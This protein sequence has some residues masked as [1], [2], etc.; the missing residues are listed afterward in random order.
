[1]MYNLSLNSAITNKCNC[2]GITV[3]VLLFLCSM[4][5]HHKKIFS[6][7]KTPSDFKNWTQ[8]VLK[9]NFLSAMFVCIRPVSAGWYLF[10]FVTTC[11]DQSGAKCWQNEKL[12]LSVFFSATSVITIRALLAFIFFNPNLKHFVKT[13]SSCHHCCVTE[14]NRVLALVLTQL[15]AKICIKFFHVESCSGRASV[16]HFLQASQH[17][18]CIIERR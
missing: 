10:L 12:Y 15:P 17:S 5:S 1:M 16:A 11:S 18:C 13:L 14:S 9:H 8:S 2:C 3:T 4:I 6:Q 7:G